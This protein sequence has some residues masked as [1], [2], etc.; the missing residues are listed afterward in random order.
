MSTF[1]NLAS[2]FS[3][4]VVGLVQPFIDKVNVINRTSYNLSSWQLA[5]LK[6]LESKFNGNV[7]IVIHN[8]SLGIGPFTIPGVSNVINFDKPIDI[9]LAFP[10][11]RSFIN[12]IRG[13]KMEVT[14]TG[15]GFNVNSNMES[16]IYLPDW[17]LDDGKVKLT[18][19]IVNLT[20]DTRIGIVLHE[21]G[22]W[23]EL[24]AQN[25]LFAH[26]SALIGVALI[27]YTMISSSKITNFN[28]MKGAV[29]RVSVENK[30]LTFRLIITGLFGLFFYKVINQLLRSVVESGSDTYASNFG[31]GHT[32]TNFLKE[33]YPNIE[34]NP[35]AEFNSIFSIISELVERITT[36]YPSLNWRTYDLLNNI[37]IFEN[38]DYI[39]ELDLS[40]FNNIF[41]RGLIKLNQAISKLTP[42]HQI[43]K[44]SIK[45][46]GINENIN[47]LLYG[48]N[49]Y[50]NY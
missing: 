30:K 13:L 14:K 24:N 10:S 40:L 7:K 19:G 34:Y 16:V 36:G 32:L 31:Y 38:V 12:L 46:M 21:L 42:L 9:L 26:L 15:D 33:L 17:V 43:R 29:D 44:S 4:N 50:D 49:F 37:T 8:D 48:K 1:N 47:V 6:E 27:L 39:T 11:I 5:N 22:H 45:I 2:Q 20:D 23:D 35:K 41:E 3:S 18:K 28:F 25:M